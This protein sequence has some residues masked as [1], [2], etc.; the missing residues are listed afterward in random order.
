MSNTMRQVTLKDMTTFKD[1]LSTFISWYVFNVEKISR[2]SEEWTET[3]DETLVSILSQGLTALE[4]QTD[5]I[6]E[7]NQ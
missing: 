1:C 2:I 4:Q 3:E 7:A 6:K 5:I